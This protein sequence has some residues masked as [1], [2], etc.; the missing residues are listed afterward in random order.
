MHL[1]AD[2]PGDLVQ[3]DCVHICRLTGTKGRVWQYTAIDVASSYVWAEVHV[4][5]LNPSAW[6]TSG[7]VRRVARELA[8]AGWKLTAF[9]TS[10]CQG[11]R[12]P[13]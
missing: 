6:N 3:I 12:D 4:T 11:K 7:L 8:E 5:D 2:Q 1:E 10:E 13:A 9:S